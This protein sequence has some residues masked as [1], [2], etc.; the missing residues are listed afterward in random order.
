M[1][2]LLES[3]LLALPRRQPSGE[4]YSSH[5]FGYANLG[6]RVRSPDVRWPLVIIWYYHRV[7]KDSKLLFSD[8]TYNVYM[9]LRL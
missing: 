8:G 4:W 3:F 5:A 9:H 2:Q 6:F 1:V 7:A